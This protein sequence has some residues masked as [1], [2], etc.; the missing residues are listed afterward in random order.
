MKP[1]TPQDLIP[2]PA[3]VRARD[4]YLRTIIE[5]K[6]ARRIAVGDSVTAVFED[7]KTVLF[8][9]Q[10]MLRAE[11]ITRA[12]AIQHEL[13]TY[14][15]LL[16]GPEE[17]SAT[18]LIDIQDRARI[19]AELDRLVGLHEHCFLRVG[20]LP[21]AKATFD[22]TQLGEQRISAVQYTKLPVR[23]VLLAAFRDPAVPAALVIDHP[24]YR[25]EGVLD[26]AV[27]AGLIADLA[28]S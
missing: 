24:A 2:T 16:P 19:R 4:A 6:K 15:A 13:D 20:D 10:E 27:R 22:E 14:N 23:G 5:H 26:G 25:A 12:D 17:L 3:Y 1:V 11:G 8:Q 28:T 7:R 21:P 9:V 18:L